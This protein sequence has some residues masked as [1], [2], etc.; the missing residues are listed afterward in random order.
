MNTPLRQA[1]PS[2][3]G[4]KLLAAAAESRRDAA[5]VS[6]RLVCTARASG[7]LVGGCSTMIVAADCAAS[8]AVKV[9]CSAGKVAAGGMEVGV[10]IGAPLLTCKPRTKASS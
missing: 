3:L 9:G 1:E 10:P 8:A 2:C 7:T 5:F 4:S 6:G